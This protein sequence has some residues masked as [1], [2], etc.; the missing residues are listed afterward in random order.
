MAWASWLNRVAAMGNFPRRGELPRAREF[1]N[2]NIDPVGELQALEDDANKLRRKEQEDDAV[3]IPLFDAGSYRPGSPKAQAQPGDAG[4]QYLH[5]LD[6]LTECTGIPMRI[7]HVQ[8]A[9]EA[10]SS[11]MKVTHNYSV[12]WYIWLLR[13]LHSHFDNLFIRYFSRIA[14]AQLPQDVADKLRQKLQGSIAFWR[15]R[16]ALS[17]GEENAD[18]RSVAINELRL[19]LTVQ[20][21]MT[22]RMTA[23]DAVQ[24]FQLGVQ[25]AE[26]ASVSHRWAIEAAGEL[27]K[28]ALEA[29]PVDR[30]ASM[31]FDVI[32][33]PL[34]RFPINLYRIRKP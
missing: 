27:A 2:V 18:D 17:L 20:S 13:N 32:K 12:R 30:Q 33:F 1:R 5:E 15:N 21:H 8:V 14:I 10:A 6:Q 29:M 16:N 11:I 31:A 3:I 28:Y 7:N 25:I 34:E 24:A 22:V 19:A 4:F 26:D 9:A 23:D